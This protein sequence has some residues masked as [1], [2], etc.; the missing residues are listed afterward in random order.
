MRMTRTQA[1]LGVLALSL[2]LY[3]PSAFAD[4]TPSP[5]PSLDPY[6]IAQEQFKKDRDLFMIANKAR[7]QAMRDI[8]FA[9]KVAVDKATSDARLAMAAALTPE[10]KNLINSTR[11]N[12]VTSAIVARDAAIM[13]L[14]PL[15]NPP[16]EPTRTNKSSQEK[17]GENKEKQKR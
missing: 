2:S 13:A 12:A 6:K 7:E 4:V 8:N 17:G 14:P 9:F 3:L 16:V 5:A 1:L 10:K 11:R 15:P